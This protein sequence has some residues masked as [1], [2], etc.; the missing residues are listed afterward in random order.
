[1][2][3]IVME[4]GITVTA[5]MRIKDNEKLINDMQ[6]YIVVSEKELHEAKGSVIVNELKWRIKAMK[7]QILELEAENRKVS[8]LQKSTPMHFPFYNTPVWDQFD[9]FHKKPTSKKANSELRRACDEF[10]ETHNRVGKKYPQTGAGDSASR[11]MII[12][13]IMDRLR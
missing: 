1:M 11:D 7:D 6:A 5:E 10:I 3:L 4:K 2:V 12:R 9:L 8:K 13:Y